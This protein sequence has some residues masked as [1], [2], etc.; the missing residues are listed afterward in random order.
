MSNFRSLSLSKGQGSL[1]LSKGH[2]FDR[3]ST[4]KGVCR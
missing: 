1:S 4:R 3:L 2:C